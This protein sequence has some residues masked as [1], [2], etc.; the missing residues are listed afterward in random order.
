[1]VAA[2]PQEQ[3]QVGSPLLPEESNTT[4]QSEETMAVVKAKRRPA[5][6]PS[7]WCTTTWKLPSDHSG[8][9]PIHLTRPGL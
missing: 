9:I 8:I 3:E 1:M 4:D 5:S 6:G 2:R 7:P